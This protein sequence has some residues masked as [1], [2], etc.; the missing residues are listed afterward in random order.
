MNKHLEI[1]N[2]GERK[3]FENFCQ[4]LR[5]NKYHYQNDYPHRLDS[6]TFHSDLKTVEN[7][8]SSLNQHSED[9]NK[10]EES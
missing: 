2:T 8:S 3:T 6:F 4:T 5:N 7:A 9:S 10:S 1:L